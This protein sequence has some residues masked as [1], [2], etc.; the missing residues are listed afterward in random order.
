MPGCHRSRYR[1]ISR[2]RS[3][4][5]LGW[6]KI[7]DMCPHLTHV[8]CTLRG[9]MAERSNYARK[10]KVSEPR[11]TSDP[12]NVRWLYTRWPLFSERARESLRS[13][14]RPALPLDKKNA[15]VICNEGNIAGMKSTIKLGSCTGSFRTGSN[16][17]VTW[18]SRRDAPRKEQE[19]GYGRE[20]PRNCL[21]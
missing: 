3:K 12:Y 9:N 7:G 21:N 13:A 19:R 16:L 18:H 17:A 6:K 4:K 15:F 5:M 11:V 8:P 1:S 10:A 14:S 20:E 2:K